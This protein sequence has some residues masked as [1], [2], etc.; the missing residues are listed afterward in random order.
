MGA[1]KEVHIYDRRW[2]RI[3]TVFMH[4]AYDPNNGEQPDVAIHI[5]EFD[6]VADGVLA[7]P[8]LACKRCTDERNVRKVRPVVIVEH[9]SSQKRYSERPKITAS[10]DAKIRFPE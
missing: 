5:S 1:L 10:R 9:P 7:G 4:I 8:A 2:W 6:G 3:G